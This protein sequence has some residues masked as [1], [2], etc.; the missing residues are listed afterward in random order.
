MNF[1]PNVDFARFESALTVVDTHT[2]GEFI[3]IVVGGLPEIKGDTMLEKMADLRANYD[4]IRTALMLEPRGHKDM[5]GAIITEPVHKEAAFGVVFIETDDYVNM[6]GHGSIG[7]ATMAVETG[8]VEAVEPYTDLVF[9]APAGVIR[10]KVK[11][12]NGK[13]VEVSITNVPS[14][15]YKEN[16]ET[17]VDGKRYKYDIAFGGQFFPMVDVEQTGLEINEENAAKLIDLG[18]KILHNVAKEQIFQHPTLPITNVTSMEFYGKPK[19]EGSHL[20]NIVVFGNHQADR[21]PCGTGTSAKLAMWYNEGKVGIGDVI[22]NESCMGSKFKGVIKE[23]V[24]LGDYTAVIPEIT[25]SA[26]L[27]G[28]GTYLIDST[29]P[30][31]Y[32]FIL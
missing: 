26:Y 24:Q 21:S 6:C 30:L 32:G 9:D 17:V 12:E 16:L 31:K 11:V 28:V 4:H 10:A 29:D 1:K 14:F 20:R 25:G 22:V 8:M 15:L 27:T 3:R 23:V 5:F 19:D 7:C 2:E 18:I 13:A